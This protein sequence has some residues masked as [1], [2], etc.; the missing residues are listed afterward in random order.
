MAAIWQMEMSYDLTEGGGIGGAR[1]S[2]AGLK[3][4]FGTV[5]IGRHNTPDKGAFYAAGNDH[6]GD[7]VIDLNVSMG[8]QEDRASSTIAY[9]SPSYG[10][11]KFAVAIVPG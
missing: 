1:N 2:F 8:F 10:A 9:M 6:L 4:D 11:V 3:G 7:S 5:L